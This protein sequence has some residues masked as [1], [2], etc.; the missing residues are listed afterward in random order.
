[1]ATTIT[2]TQ[3]VTDFGAFYIDAGQNEGNIH[4]RLRESFETQGAFTII[5]T[6]DTV[7][8]ESN[9]QFTEVLQGFQKAFTPKGGVTFTP[10]AI[11]LYNVKVDQLFYPDDL[12]N[13]WL[14]FLTSNSLDRTTWPFVRWFIESYVMGQIM[15]DM[16]T[17]AIYSGVFAAP[18]A[19]TANNAN[20]IMNGVKKIINDAVTGTTITP[21]ATG[22]PSTTA[23]TW[24][25]QVEDFTKGIPELYWN[26]NLQ[27]N[28]SRTLARRYKEGRRTKYNS[29]YAQV[30]EQLAVEDTDNTSVI[31]RGSMIG[32][33]KI[34]TT[35]KMNA[36][37]AFKGGSNANI[38]EVEKVDRQ[39]K[40]YTDF[41]VGAG[42]I[43]DGLVFTN[44]RD[45]V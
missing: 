30:S 28:M 7:L 34:W 35:P 3:V 2:S 17:Q 15:H 18:T 32:A 19:G 26:Q 24:C 44:D 16:E 25:T 12:K 20:Q 45:L 38:V 31:G 1:M 14:S 42:F 21:I 9:T 4:Q 41:W 22:A 8:R 36:I 43:D 10:K 11:P 23:L 27:I 6:E 33:T 5:D 40:V 37:L 13:Q 29:N 39:V